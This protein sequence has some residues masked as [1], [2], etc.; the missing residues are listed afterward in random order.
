M[1]LLS[2]G[3][4]LEWKGEEEQEIRSKIDSGTCLKNTAAKFI[5][6]FI[7]ARKKWPSLRKRSV[8][9]YNSYSLDLV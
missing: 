9:M 7:P 6:W 5:A 2:V 3:C 1:N 4:L 8:Y